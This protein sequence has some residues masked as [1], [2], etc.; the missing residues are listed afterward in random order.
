[1]EYRFRSP[2]GVL[3]KEYIFNNVNWL[4]ILKNAIFPKGGE[5]IDSEYI[6]I[7]LLLFDIWEDKE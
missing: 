1:M 4:D 2:E 6:F 5:E 3:W 7:F